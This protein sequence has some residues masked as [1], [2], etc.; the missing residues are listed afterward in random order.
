MFIVCFQVNGDSPMVG[1]GGKS[2]TSRLDI[3]VSTMSSQKG[4]SGNQREG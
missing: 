4:P 1:G 2:K 3:P